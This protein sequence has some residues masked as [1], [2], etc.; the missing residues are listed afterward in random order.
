M[1]PK[2]KAEAKKYAE[3]MA[4]AL[5]HA[6]AEGRREMREEAI[7]VARD[8]FTKAPAFRTKHNLVAAIR[9]LPDTKE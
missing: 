1:T 5:K 8:W 9:S 7:A 4:V 2:D 3:C 6:H